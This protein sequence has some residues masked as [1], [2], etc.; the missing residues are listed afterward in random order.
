MPSLAD[1]ARLIGFNEATTLVL[2]LIFLG[3]S[4]ATLIAWWLKRDAPD[5]GRSELE[6]RIRSWWVIS[7]LIAGSLIAGKGASILLFAVVSF[8]ALK[9]FYSIIPVRP[10]DR[11]VLFWAYLAIPIQFLLIWYE[12]YGIFIVFVPV[13]MF[14]IV[15]TVMVIAGSTKGF[16]KA[17]GTLH[18][19]LMTAVYSLGHI[20]YLLV[21]PAEQQSGSIALGAGLVMALIVLTELNDVAQ[22]V[23]GKSFGRHRIAPSVSPNKT[24]EGFLGGVVTTTAVAFFVLPQL[25]PHSGWLAIGLG[26][27][28]AVAGFFGDLT[29]SAVKRDLGIKDSGALIPGHGGILDRVDSLIFTAPLFFHYTR[30]F[31]WEALGAT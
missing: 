1:F 5:R 27:L 9:E 14:L 8:L 17:A 12:Q 11:G 21:L 3:L 2:W 4:A 13:Y 30:Y 20:A 29:E 15:P 19:G 6:L 16:L 24:W 18:W 26:L 10:V 31:Q 28:V 23:W 22:Y 7:A 25:T